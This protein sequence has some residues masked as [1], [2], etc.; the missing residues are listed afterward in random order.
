MSSMLMYS[1]KL[2]PAAAR[3]PDPSITED[4][5]LADRAAWATTMAACTATAWPRCPAC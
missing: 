3:S 4:T 1:R 2:S 5:S